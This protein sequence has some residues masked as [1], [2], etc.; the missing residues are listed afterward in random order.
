[1]GC[2]DRATHV[3]RVLMG[4][5]VLGAGCEPV[6]G[7]AGGGK[8]RPEITVEGGL[9]TV[10]TSATSGRNGIAAVT[11]EVLDGEA[12]MLLTGE[13][14]QYLS[15][16]Y[17]DDPSGDRVFTWRDWYGSNGLTGAI[18]PEAKDMAVNW[19]VRADDPSLRAGMWTLGLATTNANGYYVEDIDIDV[20]AQFKKD[21]SFSSGKV[22]ALV[23]YADG[24]A[25][26]A[27]VVRGTEAAVARW[28]DVWAAAG[29]E[30]EVR[31]TET[32]IDPT[33]PT[34]YDGGSAD[35]RALAAGEGD[36]DDVTVVIGD[37]VGNERNT[38]G[39]SG[40]IPGTLVASKRAAVVVGWIANAG[41]DGT[42]EP[43]DI[44]LYGETLA[45]EVGHYMGLFHPV[46]ASYDYWDALGDTPECRNARGCEEDLGTNN[47]F[48]YPVCDWRD[49]VAQD[50]ITADQ[51]GVSNRYTG[52]L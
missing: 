40:G 24:L 51:A 15:L 22:R 14:G 2:G 11:V 46:E 29:I 12:A 31:Y 33:L 38:Y 13:A 21:D 44:Q 45:H 1:M 18:F 41:R 36:D 49:C 20:T 34:M 35:L 39:V 3:R 10:R 48:P 23:A 4:V 50:V 5:A 8:D 9:R 42:F 37:S 26:D 43:A 19:P 16:E 52:A 17:I 32:D 30:L 7:G 27:E 6:G 28:A 47:M 25:A